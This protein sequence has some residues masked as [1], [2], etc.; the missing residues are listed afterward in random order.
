MKSLE[1]L[2]EQYNQPHR[3]YHTLEHIAYMFNTAKT[4]GITLTEDQK[5]AI[6]WHDAVYIAGSPTNEEESIVLM[7]ATADMSYSSF[8]NVSHM[9]RDT[10]DHVPKTTESAIVCDLDMFILAGSFSEYYRYTQQVRSEFSM[11]E[12]S[13][14]R[15]NRIKFLE[16]L[17]ETPIFHSDTF[18][19]YRNKAI[20]SI[21]KEI[22]ELK[23][24]TDLGH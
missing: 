3:H 11:I 19:P 17:K 20:H 16:Y 9:I 8:I 2:T 15:D 14:F 23:L 7:D 21:S 22:V 10:H 13:V 1:V 18:K 5:A 12:R 6:W 4:F 24:L